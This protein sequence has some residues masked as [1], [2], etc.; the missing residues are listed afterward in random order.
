MTDDSQ[1][2]IER[3]MLTALARRE[4]G[5]QELLDKFSSQF[6][7]D[8]VR[9]VLDR[10]TEDNW[11]SDE[12]YAQSYTRSAVARGKGALFIRQSLRQN[13]VDEQWINAALDEYDFYDLARQAFAK[14]YA[15][16]PQEAKALAKCQRFLAGRGFSFDQINH[17]IHHDD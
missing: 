2:A 15:K 10:L 8:E 12:R 13:G 16:P 5:Y 3:K 9:E 7:P 14:K 1:Q 17:A 11:Q 6:E 4:Y